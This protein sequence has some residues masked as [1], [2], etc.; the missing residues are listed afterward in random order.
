MAAAGERDQEKRD[1]NE[2]SYNRP[3]IQ[4]KVQVR[5]IQSDVS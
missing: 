3:M 2:G 1:A 4:E 5:E